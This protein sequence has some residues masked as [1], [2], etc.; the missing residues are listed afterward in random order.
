MYERVRWVTKAEAAKELEISLSTLDRKIKR[1]EVEVVREGRRVYV[2]MH[3]P[4]HP[5]DGEVLRQA[6]TREDE[7]QRTVRELERNA[8]ESELRASEVGRERDG[9]QGVRLRH[10]RTLR[11]VAAEVLEGAG[12]AREYKILGL[13]IGPVRR[14]PPGH[15]LCACVATAWRVIC[16]GWRRP[17]TCRSSFAQALLPNAG[18]AARSEQDFVVG[19]GCRRP[20]STPSR[21]TSVGAIP[22]AYRFELASRQSGP[23]SF[24]VSSTL[25]PP[26]WA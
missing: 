20:L 25:S 24:E 26:V 23:S 14:H 19:R 21:A 11:E 12:G 22:V 13:R 15:H 17:E 3:G 5:N 7:L 10:W 16:Q 6:I 8:S 18:E 4:E 2:G 9:A 1:G